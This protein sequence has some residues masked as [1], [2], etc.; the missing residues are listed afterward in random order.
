MN[1]NLCFKSSSFFIR[2]NYSRKNGIC[3]WIDCAKSWTI[4]AFCRM[5]FKMSSFGEA[6]D[7]YG[8]AEGF[9][10]SKLDLNRPWP[11]RVADNASRV[12]SAE[13]ISLMQ[14]LQTRIAWIFTNETCVRLF[15]ANAVWKVEMQNHMLCI[16]SM[17]KIWMLCEETTIGYSGALQNICFFGC[18]NLQ[19]YLERLDCYTV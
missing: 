16:I 7:I 10:S 15:A 17:R 9:W 12:V 14:D 13:Y 1:W 5:P 4:G 6:S 11:P 3:Q 18:G 8:T 19:I 2:S